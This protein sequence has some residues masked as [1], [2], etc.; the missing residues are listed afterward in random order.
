LRRAAV[1]APL[2][3]ALS[4][5]IVFLPAL[6][7]GFLYWDDVK[8]IV[9]NPHL[10]HMDHSFFAWMLTTHLQGPYQPL[11]WFSFALNFFVSGLRPMGYH[12]T[13]LLLHSASAVVVYALLR[14]LFARTD[15]GWAAAAGALFFAIHPLRV[16]SVV[17]ITERRDVLSG[18]FF[19]LTLWAYTRRRMGWS[20]L[21]F[22]AAL[23]SKATTVSLIWVLV[24]MDLM[25]LDRLPLD[26]RRWT[27]REFRPVW[28]EKIPYAVMALIAGFLN[29]TAFHAQGLLQSRYGVLD[30]LLLLMHNASFYLAHIV[31]PYPLLPYYELPVSLSTMSPALALNTVGTVVLTVLFWLLRRRFPGVLVAW[32]IY[33]LMLVPVSG[34]AQNGQQIAADR[35]TYLAALPWA[36]LLTAGLAR[37]PRLR[38]PTFSVLG[39][40]GALTWAQ[41]GVWRNDETLWKQTLRFAPDT[42]L[43]ASN[44]GTLYFREGR[45]QDAAPYLKHAID[46]DPRDMEAHLNLG[47]IAERQNLPARAEAIYRHGLSSAPN[48]A[49]LKNNLALLRARQGDFPEAIRLLGEVVATRPTMAEAQLNLGLLQVHQ[50]NRVEGESHL[51]QAVLL[52]PELKDRIPRSTR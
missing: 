27:E 33:L 13:N 23:L 44:L 4:S 11:S 14:R 38:L 51:R 25:A 40:F 1:I 2:V 41:T 17:W 46:M 42:Y 19:F 8:N 18:L 10:R 26:T 9:T 39:L 3:V 31:W 32:G 43:A 47:V 36:A 50:G 29:L 28:R 49:E 52:S 21:A 30:R 12:L 34:V 24:G 22:A 35:Y 20:L 6:H 5:F 45:D 16:E 48:D 37:I 7:F 15:N